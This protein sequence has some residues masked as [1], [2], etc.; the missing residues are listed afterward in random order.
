LESAEEMT[1]RNLLH[2]LDVRVV[3]L[4]GGRDFGRCPLAARLPTALW[5]VADKPVLA[6]VL[7]HLAEA[8]FGRV[9]VCCAKDDSEAV[10]A[11]CRGTRLEAVPVVE[12]LTAGTAGCLRDAVTSDPGDLILVLSGSMLAPP[13]IAELVEVHQAATAEMTLVLNPGGCR[14]TAAGRPAEIYLCRPEVLR[15]IPH[16]GYSDIKE[17]LI[18]SIL[19]AGG[20]VRPAVLDRE[21]GNFHNR[22]GYL[23]ALEVLLHSGG[24]GLCVLPHEPSGKVLVREGCNV[25]V[26]PTAR[27]CGPVLLGDHARVGEG[28]VVIGPAVLGENVVVGADSVVVR[29]ALWADAQAGDRC[30]ICESIVDCRTILPAGAKIVER[31]VSPS[32]SG[33]ACGSRVLGSQPRGLEQVRECMRSYFDRL[34]ARLPAGAPRS[35]SY[36]AYAI[37]GL[38]VLAALLWSYG[39]TITDLLK[40]WKISDEYSCGKLVPFLTVYVLWLRRRDLWSVP[41]RPA[42]LLGMGGFLLAQ[43]VRALGLDFYSFAERFSIVLSLA[44]VVLLILGWRYLAK[45]ATVLLFLC[46][47]L[48]W[49]HRIQGI[50]TL[51]LQ[52]WSTTSAVFCLELAGY[53]VRQDGNEITMGT[54]HV[55]VAEACN[56]LRMI[57]AFFVITGLVVLLVKRAWWEKLIILASSLP[58]AF[59]CNTLR[60]AATAVCFTI[61]KGEEVEQW[62][63]D[64]AGYAMMPLALALVV[65][66]LWLLARLTTSPMEIEPAIISRQHTPHLPDLN[67]GRT[68]V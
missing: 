8:G 15:H 64:W 40:E 41:V 13:A 54:V 37:G 24:C 7:D 47:M 58:I 26:H 1:S 3:V 36:L 18:P 65:G 61:I 33:R 4:V 32:R 16:G 60:L 10:G 35:G 31:T 9:A 55:A 62:F 63:H 56:G 46:L 14:Q 50:V 66:E 30:E 22:T 11:V 21:V 51:P 17:G 25:F 34:A 38:I 12:E 2:G 53:E 67:K 28:V 44:A 5:P 43:A 48:P 20:T 27:I 29:S 39:P 23:R 42:L 52:R 6:H 49:P 57:T 68:G 45:L 19:R 59:L